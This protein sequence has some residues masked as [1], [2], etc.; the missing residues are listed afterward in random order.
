MVEGWG[1]VNLSRAV[2][3]LRELVVVTAGFPVE[4]LDRLAAVG[5][6]LESGGGELGMMWL[7]VG[8]APD[9]AWEELLDEASTELQAG[10]GDR[11]WYGLGRWD[12]AE[13]EVGSV[14]AVVACEAA[15]RAFRPLAE[16]DLVALL[17]LPWQIATATSDRYRP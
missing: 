16:G 11:E 9:V 12:R 14:M 10:L 17:H 15:A 2:R 8:R 5:H 13:T 6:R 1:G 4:V 7:V 3:V